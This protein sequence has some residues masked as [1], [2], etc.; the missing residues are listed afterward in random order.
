MA[1]Y[2]TTHRCAVCGSK[3]IDIIKDRDQAYIYH[4]HSCGADLTRPMA[5]AEQNRIDNAMFTGNYTHKQAADWHRRY[6][7][8][9][10]QARALISGAL[11]R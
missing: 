6:E 7:N 8:L 11:N 5:A 4:C 9:G 10:I 3:E 2:M 1:L